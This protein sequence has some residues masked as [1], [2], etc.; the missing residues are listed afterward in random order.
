MKKIFKFLLFV[1]IITSCK[2]QTTYP[3]SNFESKHLKNS[4]YIKDTEDVYNNFEGMWQWTDGTSIFIVKL[5]KVEYWKAPN[6]N[7]YKDLVLGGYKYIENGNLIIDKLTFITN[8]PN[9]TN[10][11]NFASIQGGVVY[12]EVNQLKM[13]VNDVLKQ[14]SCRAQLTLNSS[15]ITPTIQWK[16]QDYE[17]YRPTSLGIKPL[18]FS[19]PTDVTLT[20]I[21]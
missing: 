9:E 10:A 8:F 1:L 19:I 18:N 20:K 15:G 12:P 5:E 14:K 4:N 2:A 17:Q 11:Q 3:L 13:I 7:Y 6:N 21:P 16:L